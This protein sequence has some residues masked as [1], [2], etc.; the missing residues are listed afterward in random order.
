M[1][2]LPTAGNPLSVRRWSSA[3][4]T[5]NTAVNRLFAVLSVAGL[6]LGAGCAF[7]DDPQVTTTRGPGLV[8]I[9][10]GD[11]PFAVFNHSPGLAKP[12]FHP[13]R[14]PGGHVVTAL[15]P[16]DHKHHK[17]AWIGVEHV[18]GNNFWGAKYQQQDAVDPAPAKERIESVQVDVQ[19]GENGS[20]VLDIQNVWQGDEGQPVIKEQTKVTAYPNRLLV[21]EITLTPASGPVTFEDT[22]EGFLAVRVA[23]TMTEKSGGGVIVN[24]DGIKGEAEC[25]GKTSAWVDYS[26]PVDNKVAGIALFDHPNNFRKSRYHVRGYGLF[27]ISPFGEKVYSKDTE[28]AAPITLQPGEQLKLTYGMYAH[29]GDAAKGNVAAAYEKFLEWTK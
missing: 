26:G 8:G 4:A 22:K 21:Y 24:A 23:P 12:F 17:G 25:W 3:F 19:P 27:A 1:D 14:A 13:L 2:G 18:N 16:F 7:A 11:E 28:K 29:A 20:Q 15:A 10:V 5:G 6:S 9:R